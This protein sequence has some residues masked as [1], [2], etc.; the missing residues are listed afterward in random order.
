[1][2][3]V[4]EFIDMNREELNQLVERAGAALSAEE[5]RKLKGV[6][7]ALSY[8][9][10]LVADQQ[11]TIGDLRALLFPASTEKTKA[12]LE[13]AGLEP[14][15]KP[16]AD[17]EGAAQP[18]EPKP[19]PKAPGHGR[20]GA[21]AYRNP[22]RVRVR[23]AGLK[24]GDRCP[25]CLKGKLYEQP[26][27]R[28][29]RIVGQAPLAATIYDLECLRCNL[30]GEVYSADAPEGVGE[31]KY[32]ETAAAMIALLK[33]GTGM[34]FYRLEDLEQ[35]LGIPLP[36]STQWEIVEEAA[37][38]IK[39]ARDELIRQAAQGEILH[40]DD[41]S[42]RVLALRRE[43]AEEAGERTGIFTSGV[44]AIAE[45]NKIAL[46]FTGRE[47]AGENLEEVLKQ[48]TAER[49]TPIQMCDASSR[50]VPQ[51]MKTLIANCIAHGRRQFIQITPNFPEPCRHVLET[52]GEVYHYD[53]LAR[54]RGLSRVERLHFHQQH[55]KPVMNGLHQW[56]EGQL[57]ERK[58]EPNS[59]LGKAISY[60]LRHW[61]ALTLFLCEPGAP[62]DNNLVE[63]ALKKAIL[64]RKN[65]L[66]YKTLNGAD[67]G[68]LYM[69]L[70]H[71]CELNDVNPF[72]YLT[73]LLRH[74]EQL[75]ANPAD[76][77]PWS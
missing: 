57:A 66:F 72:D 21:E 75:A 58:V 69:S 24:H 27:R 60:M 31:D 30:C 54:E 19:K 22:R 53:H 35:N 63:R 50:N 26:P 36:A 2:I 43:I 12:V 73:E 25:G 40:N 29:V 74:A 47:H 45:G 14:T 28:L 20:N 41:T 68:D 34:P 9:T 59:G 39:A 56:M 8:L 52:L 13:K 37:E 4:I 55:S 62:L 7:E 77:M 71:T 49:P 76:W 10:D 5:H 48:R 46:F 15:S 17:T 32:D 38:P 51:S 3:T 44:V 33:Y 23:Q 1:M 42:M 61:K 18:G 11:T 70:I 16:T 64:H 6:V 65:A 67:V